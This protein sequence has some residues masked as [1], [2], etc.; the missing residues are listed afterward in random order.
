SVNDAPSFV[1]GPDP[2]VLEDAGAQ[3]VAGWATAI[4]AGPADE[5]GQTLTF[6]VTGNT[7]PAL[8]AAGPAISPTGTL[9]FTPAADANGS[10]T[11]TLALMDNG[12][13][14]NGGVDTSA[15]QTFVINASTNKVYGKLAHLGVVERNGRYEYADHPN[16]VAETEQL[17]FY[18]PYGCSK[19][20]A[21]QYTID[22]AR[23]YG[24]KTV[25][26][27]QS[28]IYGERQLGI[29]D[30]GWVAW[31]A[32]AATLGKQLTI[33][34]DGKQI[35]DVLD[36]RDLVRAYEMAYNARDSISGTAYNIGGGP[37][38][39]MSLLELLAH[40]EQVTGQPIPRVYAPPRPGDQPVFVCD[41]RSA[42][43]A[44]AWK[45]EIRVTEGVRHLIDWVRANPEL[46]A[47][48]K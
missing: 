20:V 27:R 47:W 24:L 9:T 19:G 34:G 12:G 16:G 10:A 31:F 39:T 35:R 43:V 15:A 46:F 18:S 21:D 3:T 11:I 26:F 29:E 32:I 40:L 48:M 5:S 14:A 1:K 44:L 22:Y 37:A 17:D 13:T 25:T 33:Y 2:T 30:Q 7:N 45:P 36:V 41:V 28:C 23:I 4:S 8:F 42:E 6:N 38:N